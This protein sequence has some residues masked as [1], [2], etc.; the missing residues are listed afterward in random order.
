MFKREIIDPRTKLDPKF[1][2]IIL[3]SQ[4]TI[5]SKSAVTASPARENWQHQDCF[6]QL[7]ATCVRES[8]HARLKAG[9]RT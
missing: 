3:E 9:S 5:K 6:V 2:S 8:E 7:Q 1:E 4:R